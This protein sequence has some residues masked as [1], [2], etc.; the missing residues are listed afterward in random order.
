MS[1]SLESL[2]EAQR[3]DYDASFS[4]VD[5]DIALDEPPTAGIRLHFVKTDASGEPRFR[6]LARLLARYI[7]Q[8]C[9]SAE[10]RKDLT[11]PQRNEMYMQARDLFRQ[12]ERSG[13][14]GE[15]LI[16]F[17]LETVLRA[18]QAIKKMPMTTNPKEE[19]KGSDGVHV[20]WEKE[21][22]VLELIF[23]ESKIYKSFS[24]ALRDAF[25]SMEEFHDSVTKR[26]EINTVT[27][28]F[29]DLSPDLQGRLVSYIEGENVSNCRHVQACLIGFNWTEYECLCD[30]RRGAFI[31]EFEQRYKE[32]A[33]SM[34]KNLND[35]LKE[36]KHKQL[37]FEFFMLPFKDVEA[38]RTWFRE[39]L[40]G[41]K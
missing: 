38:F 7:T 39:E 37:R 26:H 12:S 17:L 3:A 24:D 6:E 25:I 40:S 9:Y 20:R 31:K 29:S 41:I 33:K 1:L 36:F 5:H 35:K 22:G 34:R 2:L 8:F 11:E 23:A 30:G 28:G 32:W 19:R 10:R 18:P 16:Y 4:H 14:V 13:Q 27:A 21:P 15:L